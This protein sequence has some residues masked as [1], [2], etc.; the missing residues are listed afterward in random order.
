MEDNGS[1][2]VTDQ[3]KAEHMNRFFA[4]VSRAS[5]LTDLEKE[6]LKEL[7][8]QEKAPTANISLFEAPFSKN[9]LRNALRKLKL[10]KA[11]GPDKIHCE[12]LLRLGPV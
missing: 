11:P 8:T 12:M 7:K 3:K 1:T 2:L 9:E 10:K 5:E 6:K 4:S